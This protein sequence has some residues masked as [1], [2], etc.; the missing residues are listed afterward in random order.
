MH[1]RNGFSLTELMIVIAI[2]AIM[3]AIGTPGFRSMMLDNRLNSTTNS[4]LG[5]LQFARSEAVMQRSSITTCA[6]NAS[7]NACANSTNWS[8]GALVMRGNTL[9]RIIPPAS[10]GVTITASRN[11]VEYNADGTTSAATITTS[12]SRPQSRQITV[13]AIGQACSGSA[14]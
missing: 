10:A 1:Q 2:I 12:D 8:N 9:L 5:T 3:A 13:N 6:A 7:N 14:C 4:L 11:N